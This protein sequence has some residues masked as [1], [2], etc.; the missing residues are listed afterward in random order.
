MLTTRHSAH[1]TPD[2]ETVSTVGWIAQRLLIVAAAVVF[3]APFVI[4]YAG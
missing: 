3:A 2:V 4:G 1:L